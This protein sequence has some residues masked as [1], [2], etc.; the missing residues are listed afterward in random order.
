MTEARRDYWKRWAK[1][2]GIR[3]VRTLAQA[4]IAAIGAATTIGE[5]SWSMV[6]GTSLLAAAVS[7]LMSISGLPEVEE[8]KEEERDA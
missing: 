5:V 7:V 2:A 4:A 6:A 8:P 1:A 3:A